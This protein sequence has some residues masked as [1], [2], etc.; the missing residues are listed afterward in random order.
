MIVLNIV[1]QVGY[2]KTTSVQNIFIS[3][4]NG[5]FK[6]STLGVYICFLTI[7]ST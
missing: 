2:L 4:I 5:L 6:L 7:D 1:T 3:S